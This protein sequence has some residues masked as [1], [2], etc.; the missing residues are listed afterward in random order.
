MKEAG[1]RQRYTQW[2]A[3]LKEMKGK[4]GMR[5]R[6]GRGKTWK[7]G[8]GGEEYE[9]KKAGNIREEG[10]EKGRKVIERKEREKDKREDYL[11]H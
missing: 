3:I 6:E 1:A 10:Q 9:G 5:E 11:I 2:E 7:G 8:E 4:W